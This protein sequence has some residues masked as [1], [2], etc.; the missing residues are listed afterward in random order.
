MCDGIVIDGHVMRDFS[1]LLSRKQG[2]IY[3][4]ISWIT[5]NCGIA[6]SDYIKTHWEQHCGKKERNPIFWEWYVEQLLQRKHINFPKITRLKGNEWQKIRSTFSVPE[7]PF[8]RAEIECVNSTS[9]PRY[10][11]SE[12][13]YIHD[14]LIKKMNNSEKQ[15][16]IKDERQGALCKYLENSDFG[17]I[18]GTCKHCA[19]FFQIS[20]GNCSNIS[21]PNPCNRTIKQS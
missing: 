3:I 16:T 9:E 13:P 2:S 8:I 4:L 21:S 6:L 20:Q 19:S 14:P 15:Q 12:D 7:D 17:I 1:P 10:L 11:L 18:V 5:Q